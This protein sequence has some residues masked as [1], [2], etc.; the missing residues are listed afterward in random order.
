MR[1]DKKSKIHLACETE[2]EE[3]IKLIMSSYRKRRVRSLSDLQPGE[4]IQIDITR[5]DW[6]QFLQGVSTSSCSS[7]KV[8]KKTTSAVVADDHHML[9]V[10]P[11]G[12]KSVRV[13]H[14]TRQGV[15]EED[16]SLEGTNVNV[17]EYKCARTGSDAIRNARNRFTDNPFSISDEQFVT[18]A[19]GIVRS[20][21]TEEQSVASQQNTKSSDSD[22]GLRKIKSLFELKPGDHIRHEIEEQVY[23]HHLL[24]VQVVDVERLHVIHKLNTGVIEE[25]NF[26]RP[27]E[28]KVLTYD[29][30]YSEEEI[31]ERAR[32]LPRTPYNVTTSNCEHFVVEVR[33][34]KRSSAQVKQGIL[35]A[36]IGGLTGAAGAATAGA[37]AGAVVA[38]PPG[39]LFGGILGGVGGAAAGALGGVPVGVHLANR[40]NQLKSKR[41]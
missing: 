14:M 41:Q 15:R 20:A 28:I 13:I 22:N 39:A 25:V 2:H 1:L 40:E 24:V 10:Q 26:Y 35:G 21:E 33:T 11:P 3:S 37:V 12:Q 36:S 34:G 31:V 38:G 7:L 5:K 27:T 6:W 32:E 18:D 19:R 17:L 4:H 8:Y 30:P 9:V 16:V 29:S 23:K